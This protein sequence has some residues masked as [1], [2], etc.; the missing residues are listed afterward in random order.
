MGETGT[1]AGGALDEPSD[2]GETE[3]VPELA[4]AARFVPGFE[5][6][7]FVVGDRRCEIQAALLGGEREA[8]VALAILVLDRL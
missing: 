1:A 5:I 8:S 6:L 2:Y 3:P 7:E 4:T